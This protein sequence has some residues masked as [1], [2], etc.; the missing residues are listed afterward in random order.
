MRALWALVCQS[1]L[2]ASLAVR[3]A[4]ALACRA[5]VLAALALFGVTAAAVTIRFTGIAVLAVVIAAWRHSGRWRGS[6]SHGSAT[7]ASIGE[8]AARGMLHGNEG[9]IFGRTACAEPSRWQAI[10]A[11]L[12]PGVS[13]EEACGL[14][15]SA[16]FPS[17]WAADRLI[18]IK[19]TVHCAAFSQTGGGKGRSVV[20][21]LLRS[22]RGSMVVIDPKGENYAKTAKARRRMGQRIVRLDPMEIGGPGA[23]SFNP[24]AFITPGRDFLDQCR[25]LARLLVVRQGTEHEPFWNDSAELVLTGVIAFVCACEPNPAERSLE[26][27]RMLVS[28]PP[29]FERCKKWMLEDD[30]ELIRRLGGQLSWYVE[31]E[32]GGVLSNVGRHTEWA[33][34]AAV[35][36]CLSGN[37][38]DPRT[39]R[40]DGNVT[41]YLIVPAKRMESWASLVRTWVGS[42]L[43]IAMDQG[44][45]ESRRTQTLYLL[46]EVAQLGRLHALEKAASIG[47]GYGIRLYFIFQ[48]LAQVRKCY[49]EAADEIIDNIGTMLFFNLGNAFSTA[50]LLSKRIGNCT[51]RIRTPSDTESDGWGSNSAQPGESRNRS[52]SRSVNT[53]ELGRSLL[54]PDE[55]LRLPEDIGLVFH[56]NM[57]VIATRLLRHYDSPEFRWFRSGRRR[58]LGLAGGVWATLTLLA[59]IVF[60]GFVSSLSVPVLQPGG[61]VAPAFRR[62]PGGQDGFTPWGQGPAYPSPAPSYSGQR[63][64]QRGQVRRQPTEFSRLIRIR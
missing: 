37:S 28:D 40:D 51:I 14:F 32:L 5:V 8:L 25:D 61:P 47:R 23:D 44:T 26:T 21:P 33:D 6:I 24:L 54:F 49:G 12:W 60:T 35:A 42:F 64:P 30:N 19:D 29:K 34:S 22:H 56:R 2:L 58:G 43:H 27:V 17:R 52:S 10:R 41:V 13:S 11:V 53:A 7:I 59:S 9:I 50:E 45:G 18:R 46:D 48:S 62:A 31:R 39:L 55:I 1:V 3:A 36:A 20:I 57:P 15:F 63:R 38:F 4:W 16:F